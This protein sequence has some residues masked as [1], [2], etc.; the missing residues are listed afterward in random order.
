VTWNTNFA[1]PLVLEVENHIACTF[2]SYDDEQ[3]LERPFLETFL[4]AEA[5]YFCILS[6]ILGS[7]TEKLYL[8]LAA[9]ALTAEYLSTS[10]VMIYDW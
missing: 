8:K 4:M 6:G 2:C 3:Q 5:L 9:L 10:S 1:E 7:G